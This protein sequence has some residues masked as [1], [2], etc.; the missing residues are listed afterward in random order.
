MQVNLSSADFVRMLEL[1]HP[2]FLFCSRQDDEPEVHFDATLERTLQQDPER[3]RVRDE[4]NRMLEELCAM[5]AEGS[6]AAPAGTAQSLERQVTTRRRRYRLRGS[7][8][9]AAAVPPEDDAV[10]ITVEELATD[11]LAPETLQQRFRF[12]P[13]EAQVA[14]LLVDGQTNVEIASALGISPNTSYHYTERVLLKVG[15]HNR[16][17]AVSRILLA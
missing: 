7:R 6:T 5:R 14:R 15:A 3:E 9:H 11:P 8:L 13:R 16:T 17:A 1:L 4:L 2:S 12:T 10:L